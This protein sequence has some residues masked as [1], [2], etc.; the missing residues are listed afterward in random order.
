VLWRRGR[1]RR[2]SVMGDD[3][4]ALKI[5]LMRKTRRRV[6]P[7]KR[8]FHR[9]Q[10]PPKGFFDAQ[11]KMPV[12]MLV[13]VP[14]GFFVSFKGLADAFDLPCIFVRKTKVQMFRW[15]NIDAREDPCLKRQRRDW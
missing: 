13:K 1:K 10:P 12:S 7:L 6:N 3:M 9:V 14:S 15:E 8:H 11:N 2:V 5:R 4:V